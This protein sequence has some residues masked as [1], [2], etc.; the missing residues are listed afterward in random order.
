M[1]EQDL[2]I[3]LTGYLDDELDEANRKKIE[4]A[5]ETDATLKAELDAMRQFNEMMSGLGVDAEMDVELDAFW[6]EVYNRTERRT[7]WILLLVGFVGVL[8][9][10]WYLFFTDPDMHWAIKVTAGCGLLGSLLLLWSVWRER[11]RVKPH[12][13]YS[14]E[15]HR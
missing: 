2:R 8:A 1:S 3:L 12:D 7:A 11:Q 14:R 6:N 4:A 5:L 15:V 10:V 13:R 9:T